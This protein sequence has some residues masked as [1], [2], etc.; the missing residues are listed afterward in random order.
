VFPVKVKS[1]RLKECRAVKMISMHQPTM[2]NKKKFFVNV[3][4]L[5]VWTG[6]RKNITEI[7]KFVMEAEHEL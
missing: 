5:R 7:E 3:F 4:I 1:L 2:P 6:N